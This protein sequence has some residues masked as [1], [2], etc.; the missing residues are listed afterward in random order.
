L[1]LVVA[2]LLLSRGAKLLELLAVSSVS[3]LSR[4]F[5]SWDQCYVISLS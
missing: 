5:A 2:E 4:D 1:M 3:V